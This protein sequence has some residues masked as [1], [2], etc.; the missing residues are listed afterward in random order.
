MFGYSHI[1]LV[2]FTQSNFLPQTVHQ[3]E[4]G[5][6]GG[7]GMGF[8][9]WWVTIG[10]RATASKYPDYY[11]G[12]AE[13]DLGLRFPLGPVKPYIRAGLGY[14][15]LGNP[16][17]NNIKAS[18][19]KVYGLISEVGAGLDFYVTKALAIGG[20]MDAAFLRLT[21]QKISMALPIGNVNLDQNGDSVGFQLRVQAHIGLHF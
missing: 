21:R 5:F 19:V 2:Q 15:W 6:T 9:I 10:A 20:G 17:F 11:L 12:T 18:D 8:Q 3:A 16:N 4:N 13:L 14:A 7:V 1:D